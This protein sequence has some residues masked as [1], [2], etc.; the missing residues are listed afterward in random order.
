MV[1]ALSQ[2]RKLD[3]RFGAAGLLRS[4]HNNYLTLPVLFTMISGHFP[5]TYGQSW[6]WAMLAVL[7]V[8][9]WLARHYFNVRRNSRAAFALLPLAFLLLVALAWLS[10]PHSSG[11]ATR[12]VVTTAQIAPVIQTR[13]ATCHAAQPTQPGFAAPPSGLVMETHAEMELNA[14]RIFAAAAVTKTMPVGN[15]TGMTEDEREMLSAW[16]HQ[17]QN[18]K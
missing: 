6:N 8:A 5:A 12:E 2:K 15:L 10:A 11:S 18:T 16:F 9:G 17:L 13:C 3:P 1:A 14:A 7:S 4:R